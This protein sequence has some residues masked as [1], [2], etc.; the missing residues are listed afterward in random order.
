MADTPPPEAAMACILGRYAKLTPKIT[1]RP[2]PNRPP[3]GNSW[4]RVDT[5]DITR[6]AWMSSTRS[7][8]LRPM[9]PAM[10]MGGVTQPTIMATRCWRA[11]ETEAPRGGLPWNWNSRRESEGGIG[12]LSFNIITVFHY[13]I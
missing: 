6:E 7:A 4:S 5:A 3:M 8:W 13:T 11:R 9:A 10:M 1:G 2:E 12:I